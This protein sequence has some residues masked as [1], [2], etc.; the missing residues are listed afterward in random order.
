M[1]MESK[2]MIFEKLTPVAES[3]DKSL[4]PDVASLAQQQ[5]SVEELPVAQHPCE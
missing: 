5:P 1:A 4:P 3:S 2:K